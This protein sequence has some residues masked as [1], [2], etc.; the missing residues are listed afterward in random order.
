[1]RFNKERLILSILFLLLIPS[2]TPPAMPHVPE[3]FDFVLN[4]RQKDRPGYHYHI[5]INAKGKGT[6][7]LYNSQGTIEYDP[8]GMIVIPLLRVKKWGSFSLKKIQMTALLQTLDDNTFFDLAEDYQMEIG[9][10]F[11]FIQA[12]IDGQ[13]HTVDNIGVE[14]PELRAII[15]NIDRLLPAKIKVDYGE[16]YKP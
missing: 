2:C 6:Y 3:D 11:A 10:S 4:V 12:T 15:E 5:H 16:G 8:D 13:E 1:M 9:H 7:V 14:V